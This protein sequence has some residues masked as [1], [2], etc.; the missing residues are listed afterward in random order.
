MG[1]LIIS[2]TIVP[3]AY[4]CIESIPRAGKKGELGIPVK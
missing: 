1:S 4:L 3:F 2:E